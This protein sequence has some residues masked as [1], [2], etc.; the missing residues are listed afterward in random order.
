[1]DAMTFEFGATS[2]CSP[3]LLNDLHDFQMSSM[4]ISFIGFKLKPSTWFLTR[5]R[6]CFIKSTLTR[7]KFIGFPTRSPTNLNSNRFINPPI[8]LSTFKPLQLASQPSPHPT[9]SNAPRQVPASKC[10]RSSSKDDKTHSCNEKGSDNSALKIPKISAR[11]DCLRMFLSFTFSYLPLR[12][13]KNESKSVF[14]A[15]CKCSN[16]VSGSKKSKYEIILLRQFVKNCRRNSR[17]FLSILHSSIVKSLR[18][19]QVFH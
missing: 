2:E 18:L 5:T 19:S 15:G 16:E 11:I 4:T 1:M 17:C 14:E 7:L 6:S 10:I 3:R 8:I 9:F 12:T 13:N